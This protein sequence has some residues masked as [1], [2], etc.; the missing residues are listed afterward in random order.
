MNTVDAILANVIDR[1]GGDLLKD[2]FPTNTALLH[3]MNVIDI[4]GL[5]MSDT[6]RNH[7]PQRLSFSLSAKEG[8]LSTGT[9][10]AGIPQFVRYRMQNTSGVVTVWK[11][12]EIVSTIEQLTAYENNN[13]RAILF[14]GTANPYDYILSFTP[15]DG[16]A[17]EIW[18]QKFIEGFT[19]TRDDSPLPVEFAQYVCVLASLATLNDLLLL[20]NAAKYVGFIAART[21]LL[22]KDRERLERLWKN[23]LYRDANR[24]GGTARDAYDIFD[25]E[26]PIYVFE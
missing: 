11:S 4:C 22:L 19:D 18:G 10:F 20:D 17:V 5:E 26:A 12:L 14:T 6:S 16:L 2:E 8:T 13:K 24:D 21:E 3:V 15:E 9:S 23:F 7:L 25:T 1:C